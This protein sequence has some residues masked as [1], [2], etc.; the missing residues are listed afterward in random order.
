MQ[1]SSSLTPT[2]LAATV[3]R[4]IQCETALREAGIHDPAELQPLK[5]YA[6]A[7]EKREAA[8]TAYRRAKAAHAQFAATHDHDDPAHEEHQRAV[9]CAQSALTTA[10]Q[11]M[12]YHLAEWRNARGL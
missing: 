10:E 2:Q 3:G 7:A 1:T 11:V 9:A 12:T 5:A 4:A 8:L 6:E